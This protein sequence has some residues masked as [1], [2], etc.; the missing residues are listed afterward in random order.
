MTSIVADQSDGTIFISATV[1][2]IGSGM[3][4]VRASVVDERDGTIDITAPSDFQNYDQQ[5]DDD[6]TGYIGVDLMYQTATDPRF[7]PQP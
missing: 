3:L 6:G 4:A 1:N 7:E 2:D 5:P